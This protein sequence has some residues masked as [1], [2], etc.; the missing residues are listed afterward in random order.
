MKFSRATAQSAARVSLPGADVRTPHLA[1]KPRANLKIPKLKSQNSA[2][3]IA[4]HDFVIWKFG[5]GICA[6]QARWP[7]PSPSPERTPIGFA[8][9]SRDDT[10]W[11]C[12]AIPQRNYSRFSR[13]SLLPESEQRTTDAAHR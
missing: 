13:L 3:P 11:V 1:R 9:A 10:A 7:L 6:P 8:R 4:R 2:D 12:D 5:I